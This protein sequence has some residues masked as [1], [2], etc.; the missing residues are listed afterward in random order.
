MNPSDPASVWLY[1]QNGSC[2]GNDKQREL[3]AASGNL[4]Q[5]DT[6]G[7]NLGD[8]KHYNVSQ[9]RE[10]N[11]A[12]DEL[13]QNYT[14]YLYDNKV[15]FILVLLSAT[16]PPKLEQATGCTQHCSTF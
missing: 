2:D 14:D 9:N 4:G 7:L 3:L 16:W 6:V 12:R 11:V 13:R 1:R 10:L 8:G 15:D 5:I